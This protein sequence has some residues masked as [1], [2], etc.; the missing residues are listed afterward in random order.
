[1][2]RA[3]RVGEGKLPGRKEGKGREEKL[4]TNV[5]GMKT[6]SLSLS[7]KIFSSIYVYKSCISLF[8]IYENVVYLLCMVSAASME[9]PMPPPV[10][11]MCMHVSSNSIIL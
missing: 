7:M 5:Y 2:L 11:I 4:A 6:A 1:M 10:P 8:L 3:G 9:M